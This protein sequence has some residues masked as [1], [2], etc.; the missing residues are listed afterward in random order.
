MYSNELNT[1]TSS[2]HDEDSMPLTEE[3]PPREVYDHAFIKQNFCPIK[4]NRCDIKN[5]SSD[6]PDQSLGGH[7]EYREELIDGRL[8][9]VYVY[10]IKIIRYENDS[11][12]IQ[13]KVP[14]EGYSP[15]I[16]VENNLIVPLNADL[17]QSKQVSVNNSPLIA[18][19]DQSAS[20]KRGRPRKYPKGEE[21]YKAKRRMAGNTFENIPERRFPHQSP[22]YPQGMIP[23]RSNLYMRRPVVD[24]HSLFSFENDLDNRRT[25]ATRAEAPRRDLENQDLA[26]ARD[27]EKQD[28]DNRR[29]FGANKDAIRRDAERPMPFNSRS[30]NIDDF[31]SDY[32]NGGQQAPPKDDKKH[33]NRVDSNIANEY[34]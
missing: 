15:L 23:G 28:L 14:E 31:L 1:E 8:A 11:I 16:L 2:L 13:K 4:L 27:S 12:E 32:F 6:F 34:F 25:F 21:P 9:K 17:V 20:G 24:P 5:L 22:Q 33:M 29:S 19:G 18:P 30:P 26:N 10:T 7:R 3:L